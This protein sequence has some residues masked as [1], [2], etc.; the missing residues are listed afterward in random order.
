MCL[1]VWLGGWRETR[2]HP[3]QC[4]VGTQERSQTGLLAAAQGRQERGK[5]SPVRVLQVPRAGEARQQLCGKVRR[6][7]GCRGG[8][9]AL[10]LSTGLLRKTEGLVDSAS[11]GLPP[12]MAVLSG[13]CT[14]VSDP[15]PTGL[16]R[17]L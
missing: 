5:R 6:E 8:S 11:L 2:A 12:S 1:P 14:V 10:G 9:K 17:G 3:A 16:W 4:R 15:F 7:G 13:P